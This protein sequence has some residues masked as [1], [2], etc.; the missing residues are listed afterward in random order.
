MNWYL[1]HT[2]PR[3]EKTA[4]MHLKQ[5]GYVCY[6]PQLRTERLRRRKL[7]VVDVPLFSRYLFI[8]LGQGEKDKSW[9]PIRSTVGVS[10]L[11]R[12]GERLA[13]ADESLIEMLK[14]REDAFYSAPERI[15]NPGDTVQ[16]SEGPFSGLDAVYQ[17]PDGEQRAL[18]LIEFL[19][20]PVSLKLDLAN[21]HKVGGETLS[22]S[23]MELR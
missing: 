2:K 10:Q 8:R 20:K 9:G 3:Q 6:L 14:A 7:A 4:L 17:M 12:F 13:H 1:L 22:W 23:F 11:V 18:V 21:L 5:Q 15:F 19:S 16:I